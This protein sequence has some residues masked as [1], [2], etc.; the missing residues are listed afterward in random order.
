MQF[1]RGYAADKGVFALPEYLHT[2]V[3]KVLKKTVEREPRPVDVD[4]AQL[5]VEIF[6]F[7]DEA[8]L[9]AIRI[10]Q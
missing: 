10:T 5:S 8:D 2:V 1:F 6:V 3:G 9:H 7:I 4:V